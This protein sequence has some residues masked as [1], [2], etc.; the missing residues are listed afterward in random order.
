[1]KLSPS[2][3]TLL[4]AVA[5]PLLVD[6]HTNNVCALALIESGDNMKAVGAAGE[7]TAWQ[8]K[9]ATWR[10]YTKPGEK[11]RMTSRT[12]AFVIAARIY[13]HNEVRFVTVHGRRP[14]A[15]EVY[16]MWNLGWDGFKRRGFNLAR[17][18]RVTRD[19][20]LRY[21]NL[22]EDMYARN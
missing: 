6:A 14:A 17:C 18:P 3:A 9:P 1:M 21:S 19:A 13:T 2:I 4:L 8:I 7:R 16:A 20:A 12:D 22:W 10:A 15:W 11:L 5:A